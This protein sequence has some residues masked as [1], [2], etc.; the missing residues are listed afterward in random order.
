MLEYGYGIHIIRYYSIPSPHHQVP[1]TGLAMA[2]YG[3]GI[4][5]YLAVQHVTI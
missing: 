1:L 3:I 2:L 4:G 5:K